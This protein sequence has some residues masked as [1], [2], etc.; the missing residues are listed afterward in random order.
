MNNTLF[1]VVSR[2]L[3]S[4]GLSFVIGCGGND[5]AQN[6]KPIQETQAQPQPAPL[7]KVEPV[8]KL[9]EPKTVDLFQAASLG[10]VNDVKFYLRS[11]PE[12]L[13]RP[14][15]VGMYPVHLAA[16]RGQGKVLQILLQAGADVDAPQ[17]RVQASPLQ[18][19]ATGGYVE[20]VRVLLD[21]KA[22]VNATDSVGRTPLMWAATKGRVSVVKMLLERGVDANQET[23]TGWTALMY[24]E[25]GKHAEVVEL[26]S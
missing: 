8:E 22:N 4:C 1:T 21:A 13:H 9:Q 23:P 14:N 7:I 17:I 12:A 24:A 2:G 11:D 5:A 6:P 25:Q 3:L 10:N 16:R 19:A 26:L 15:E 18:Y 20:A